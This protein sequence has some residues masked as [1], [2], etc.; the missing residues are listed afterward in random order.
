MAVN[1]RNKPI[2]RRR[3][4]AEDRQFNTGRRQM[5]VRRAAARRGQAAYQYSRQPNTTKRYNNRNE[6]A[7]GIRTQQMR[8]Q[9]LSAD[10]ARQ[11]QM[12]PPD[13]PLPSLA[14]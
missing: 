4:K 5:A 10:K 12:R 1:L 8:M 2:D 7:P 6:F 9:E 13:K 11:T 3:L 14:F